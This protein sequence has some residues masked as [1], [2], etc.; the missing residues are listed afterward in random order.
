MTL[1]SE[2]GAETGA[3]PGTRPPM[4]PDTQPGTTPVREPAAWARRL[5]AVTWPAFLS[6]CAL[7]LLVFSVVDPLE[8]HLP[9]G[10]A[11]WTR[12]AVYTLAFF[13]FWLVSMGSN[14]LTAMLSEKFE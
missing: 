10:G 8:L 13:A 14:A 7:E 4:Q 6:A 3:H 9:G 5:M 1:A 2:P 11:G 12:E